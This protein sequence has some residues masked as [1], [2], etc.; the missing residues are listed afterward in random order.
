M[1]VVM[2]RRMVGRLFNGGVF[3]RESR[4]DGSDGGAISGDEMVVM[5]RG[6]VE[7]LSGAVWKRQRQ[8]WWW[9]RYGR[10]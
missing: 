10:Q 5:K 3:K 1:V 2:K 8:W 4:D 9:W 7:M 6:I